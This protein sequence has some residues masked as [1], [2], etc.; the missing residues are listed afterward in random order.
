MGIDEAL[1]NLFLHLNTQSRRRILMGGIYSEDFG[2]FNA[3]GQGDAF[4]LVTA[5]L[6]VSVQF[7]ALDEVAQA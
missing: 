2:T 1:V 3:L 7:F 5:L 4:T 6:F